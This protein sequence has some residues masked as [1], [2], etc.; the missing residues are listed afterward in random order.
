MVL[1]NEIHPQPLFLSLSVSLRLSPCLFHSFHQTVPSLWP[2]KAWARVQEAERGT[3][4]QQTNRTGAEKPYL[5]P[6]QQREEPQTGGVL[7]QAV[8]RAAP[9]QVS[10]HTNDPREKE[11][12]V[13]LPLVSVP[14]IAS[15]STSSKGLFVFTWLF[16][17]V[18][19]LTKTKH[20]DKQTSAALEKKIRAEREARASIEKQMME[21]QA[22]KMEEAA[23]SAWNLANRYN[24][25]LRG[26]CSFLSTQMAN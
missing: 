6:D 7:A 17:R 15:I 2:S 26:D 20:K 13:W 14:R 16:L 4:G 10:N 3:A 24:D 9:K 21:L 11:V 8:Q 12:S 19:C 22:Q 25:A 5:Q 23:N 1:R 18:L